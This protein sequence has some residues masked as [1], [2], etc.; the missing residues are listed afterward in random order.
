MSD[1]FASPKRRL[2]P[3]K[4]HLPNVKSRSGSF[5]ATKPYAK[6]IERNAAGFEEHK[7]KLTADVPD[8]I[9]DI[10]YEAI[11]ALRSVLDQT[12]YAIAVA[13]G[14]KRPDLIHFPVGDTPA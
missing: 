11:E 4:E 2:R 3:P 8:P 6:A 7:I 13:S 12:T 14:S 1:P 9:T 5:F 10:A